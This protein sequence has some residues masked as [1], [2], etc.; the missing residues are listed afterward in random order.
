M[1]RNL[2]KSLVAAGWLG[3]AIAQTLSAADPGASH[4]TTQPAPAIHRT[5]LNRVDVPGSAYEVVYVLVDIAA[6]ARVGRHTHPG[7]VFA[8]LLEGDYSVLIDGQPLR[9]VKPGETWEVPP[10]VVHDEFTGDTPARIL[11][12]FTVEKGKALT[13]MVD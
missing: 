12:V 5:I 9:A 10:G 6:H 3:V 1:N 7:S 8:Y 13:S 11:A 4:S 2:P